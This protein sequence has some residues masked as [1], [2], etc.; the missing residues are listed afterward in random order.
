[1]RTASTLAA[2]FAALA[3][4]CGDARAQ[5]ARATVEASATVVETPSVR[6]DRAAAT[7]AAMPGE[8]RVAVPLTVSGAGSP[9]VEVADGSGAGACRAV[10]G[11]SR[12]DPPWL[13]CSVPRGAAAPGGA[14][15]LQVTL[16]IVPA[17]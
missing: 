5:S 14:T 1:M 10:P 16:L 17:T 13:R 8:F 3:L 2:F 9:R 4:A 6:M 15:E 12:S 11:A 7:V